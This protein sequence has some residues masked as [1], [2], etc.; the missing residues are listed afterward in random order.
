MNNLENK[1]ETVEIKKE[2]ESL[3]ALMYKPNF[4]DNKKEAEEVIQ[5][6]KNLKIALE[7]GNALDAGGAVLNI[8]AGVGGDDSEDWARMLLNM[9]LKYFEKKNWQI[10]FLDE[11]KNENGGYR[12]ISLEIM[13]KNIYGTLKNES[14]VH[15][16]VRISPFN[17][18]GKR[19]T[20]FAMVEILPILPKLEFERFKENIKGE[21]I[22]IDTTKSSGPGGQNVNK[23]ETAVRVS[24]KPTNISVFISNE[25]SQEQNKEKAL[26]ILYSKLFKLEEENRKKELEGKQISKTVEIEWGNQIRNYI[27]HPYKLIK[28]LRSGIE[29]NNVDKVLLKGD[30]EEFL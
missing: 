30:L 25:R 16:L 1:K 20:S 10:E 4:W 22:L 6:I 11:N 3:E 24:H 23:R 13:G 8:F 26:A 5:K 28:D 17:A 29:T 21:D 27:L 18:N 15:R 2:I 9:Y 7:G 12:N 14:G 19:H